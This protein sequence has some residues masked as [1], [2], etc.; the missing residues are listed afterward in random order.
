MESMSFGWIGILLLALAAGGGIFALVRAVVRS[1]AKVGRL[2]ST[3][4]GILQKAEYEAENTPKSLSS[5][6]PL[7]LDRI[8]R[9]FP[10]A[11]IYDLLFAPDGGLWLLGANGDYCI[12]GAGVEGESSADYTFYNI[13]TGLTH[14]TTAN[15]RSYVSPEG[16]ACIACTRKESAGMRQRP[17][18]RK[19]PLACSFGTFWSVACA[20]PGSVR[21]SSS[22]ETCF[23]M[24][25]GLGLA[26]PR[27]TRRLAALRAWAVPYA[28]RN[29]TGGC[30][31]TRP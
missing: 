22:S 11:H 9:D 3:V 1:A 21:S 23:R 29:A 7:L 5:A 2:A 25:T 27:V 31:C 4:T 18:E 14:M 26:W 8:R 15:S 17:R 16:D 30:A 13:A 24:S 6:E 28:R 10:Q 20:M 19:T 12:D